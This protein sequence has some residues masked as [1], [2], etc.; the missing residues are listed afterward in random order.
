[1]R[2]VLPGC[3]KGLK[4]RGVLSPLGVLL[5]VLLLLQTGAAGQRPELLYLRLNEGTG[6]TTADDALPGVAGTAPSIYSAGIWETSGQLLGGA[7]LDTSS[8]LSS[9]P[10][11]SVCTTNAPFSTGTADWT[12]QVAVKRTV[13]YAYFLGQTGQ[14]VP[15]LRPGLEMRVYASTTESRLDI[16][17]QTTNLMS[18]QSPFPMGQWRHVTLV[19]DAMEASLSVYFD[20]VLKAKASLSTLIDLGMNPLVNPQLGLVIGSDPGNRRWP[21]LVDEVRV[22]NRALSP[23]EIQAYMNTELNAFGDDVG[24]AAITSPQPRSKPFVAFTSSETVTAVVQNHGTNPLPAGAMLPLTLTVDGTVLVTEN[25]VLSQ[26]LQ[27]GESLS[28]TFAAGVDLSA[29]SKHVVEVSV[30]W[31]GDGHALN[32]TRSRVYGGAVHSRYVA[33]FPSSEDFQ[34]VSGSTSFGDSAP[35]G[36]EAVDARMVEDPQSTG[37]NLLFRFFPNPPSA[38]YAG[39]LESPVLDF[40]NTASPRLEFFTWRYFL[41]NAPP[42]SSP[43]L[44]Q[45]D[46]TEHPSGA[47]TTAV[48]SPLGIEWDVPQRAVAD[49]SSFAGKVVSVKF[50]SDMNH[51]PNAGFH[52]DDILI[53]D[54]LLGQGQAPQPGFAVFDINNSLNIGGDDV[55]FGDPGPFFGEATPGNILEFRFAGEPGQIVM[56]IHGPLN[57]AAASFPQIGQ[58]DIGGPLDPVTGIPTLTAFLFNG[59]DPTGLNPLFHLNGAGELVAQF[60]TPNLPPGIV[61]TFQAAIY[62]STTGLSL[63]NAVQLEI[64]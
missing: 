8:L 49:L 19:Q 23:A 16:V 32:D 20:G 17:H 24:V 30:T 18:I 22:W 38:N 46:V 35:F 54:H 29:P 1:M 47:I 4:R 36:W 61:S 12:F 9:S 5:G 62:N 57:P 26:A 31:P 45:V 55:A 11:S 28:H 51:D 44:I 59:A 58:M 37:G 53:Q 56:A 60:L 25:L 2:V 40:R 52:L 33:E 48:L 41:T 42:S 21:G 3:M 15:L 6:T 27:I 14:W 43:N 39:T 34:V 13:P 7:C 50:V 63:S 64:K 10:T